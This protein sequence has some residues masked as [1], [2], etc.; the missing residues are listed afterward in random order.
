MNTW[1]CKQEDVKQLEGEIFTGARRLPLQIWATDVL[2][3]LETM[4]PIVLE[5]QGATIW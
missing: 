3:A 2:T 5:R 1:C 4:A